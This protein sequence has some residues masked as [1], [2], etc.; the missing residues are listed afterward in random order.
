MAINPATNDVRAKR[1]WKN[2]EKI[3]L[4]RFF[5]FFGKRAAQPESIERPRN[6]AAT[7]PAKIFF[8]NLNF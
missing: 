4:M 2:F 8:L 3:G 5:K 7:R 6:I 1:L